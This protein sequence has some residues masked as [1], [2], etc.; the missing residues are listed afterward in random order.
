MV[1]HETSCLINEIPGVLGN[2]RIDCYLLNSFFL[3]LSMP[4]LLEHASQDDT[5]MLQ[6]LKRSRGNASPA[7]Q[8]VCNKMC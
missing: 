7:S 1:S 5:A 6:T 3:N 8:F 2:E 4:T